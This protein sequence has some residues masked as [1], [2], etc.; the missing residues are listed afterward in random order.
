MLET[1][2][3]YGLEQLRASGEEAATRTQ[4][5][6]W[7]RALAEQA[8]AAL[9]AG[10]DRAR[11]LDRLAAEHDNVRAAAAWLIGTGD[12]AAAAGLVGGVGSFWFVRGHLSEGRAVLEQALALPGDVPPGLRA[13][14]LAVLAMTSS[15]QH[16][17]QRATAAADEA[18]S[19][20]AAAA[21]RRGLALA[22]LAQT[23]VALSTGAVDAAIVSGEAS[24]ALYRELGAEG[25]LDTAY[26]CTALGL[27]ARG[28][29]ERAAALLEEGL[30]SAE[31]RGDD[32]GV[33][34]AH[35]GLGTVARDQGDN[36]RALPH[37]AAG[38]AAHHR[39]G[40]LWHA[41]WCLEGAAL[42]G[43]E[44]DPAWAARLLG[45]AEALR[46]AIGAPTPEPHRPLH[47]R[48]VAHMRAS[49][50]GARFGEAW[51]QGS[52]MT[53]ADAVAEAQPMATYWTDP[54]TS[55]PASRQR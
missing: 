41:A 52:R 54:A 32:Y 7:C 31:Q 2:R 17:F 16:D 36:A 35:E 40:E 1:V 38:L 19:V 9:S 24:I 8:D 44:A 11:H 25:D 37:F 46:S 45:A 12:A 15:F 23:I 22:R 21:D 4:H 42:A 18:A 13:R 30:Q 26:L 47:D 20:A 33:A 28:E 48:V 6:A 3:E 49:L 53:L 55:A 39:A 51:D 34:V 27:R 14:A 50:G 29:F 43:A 5:A 10:R